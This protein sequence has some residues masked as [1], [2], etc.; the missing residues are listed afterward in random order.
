MSDHA[1]AATKFW[2]TVLHYI[3][4]YIRA[5]SALDG[6]PRD[7]TA[8]GAVFSHTLSRFKGASLLLARCPDTQLIESATVL[9][10]PLMQPSYA[11]LTCEI[12]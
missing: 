4:A 6:T 11:R 12:Y 3:P 10:L 9:R 2:P 7:S 1:T 5:G 8:A